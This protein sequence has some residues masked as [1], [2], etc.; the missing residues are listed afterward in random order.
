M[1]R[2]EQAGV[3]FGWS[4]IDKPRLPQQV[5]YDLALFRDKRPHRRWPWGARPQTAVSGRP[6]GDEGWRA[7]S[8][9]AV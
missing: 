7:T 2:I 9:S 6:G 8:P 4:Q 1:V 3:D 5:E